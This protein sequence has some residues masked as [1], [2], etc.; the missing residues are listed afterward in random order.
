MNVDNWTEAERELADRVRTGRT[1]VV[2]VRKSGPHKHLVPWL[3]ER[4]LLTYIGHAGNRHSWPESE[5]ANPFVREAKLDRD[6]MVRH[7]REYLEGRADLLARLPELDGRALGC[8]CAPQAC[9][10]DVLLEHLK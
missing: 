7:Y 3:V 9:H 1:V 10:G 8:W 5:F 6:A 2:N 4:G